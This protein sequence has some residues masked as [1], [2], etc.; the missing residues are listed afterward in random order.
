MASADRSGVS[1]I[2]LPLALVAMC[3]RRGYSSISIL[4]CEPSGAFTKERRLDRRFPLGLLTDAGLP[5]KVR[6]VAG[7]TAGTLRTPPRIEAFMTV[8]GLSLIHI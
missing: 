1:V 4:R 2:D 5:L 6:A 8:G 3:R 7:N